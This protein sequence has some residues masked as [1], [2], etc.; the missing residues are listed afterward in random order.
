MTPTR[1]SL[2]AFTLAWP[3]LKSFWEHSNL[4]ENKLVRKIAPN[5]AAG[6][7][8][9][10]TFGRFNPSIASVHGSGTHAFFCSHPYL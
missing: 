10:G 5:K 6:S 3:Q 4:Q 2:G 8:Q 9:D 1:I 7:N